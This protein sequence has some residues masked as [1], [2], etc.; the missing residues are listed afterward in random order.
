MIEINNISGASLSTL[1]VL[2]P[3]PALSHRY[4]PSIAFNDKGYTEDNKY[5]E[6]V[7]D[8][9]IKDTDANGFNFCLTHNGVRMISMIQARP[10]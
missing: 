10:I 3:Q 4:P 5:Q 8:V 1:T 6:D 2:S 9:E 7:T